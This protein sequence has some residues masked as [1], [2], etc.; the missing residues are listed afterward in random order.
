MLFHCSFEEYMESSK[1]METELELMVREA[2]AKYNEASKKN[3]ALQSKLEVL[4]TSLSNE[5]RSSLKL[6]SEVDALKVSNEQ[7]KKDKRN[8]ENACEQLEDRVRI[9]EATE[10]DV[11]QKLERAEE[12]LVLAQGDFDSLQQTTQETERRFAEEI[13]ELKSEIVVMR[14]NNSGSTAS[15]HCYSLHSK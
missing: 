4:T 7:L 5:Q 12:D 6:Q 1:E 14:R 8:M 3:T 13:A 9:L 15:V 11:S 2:D 10:A